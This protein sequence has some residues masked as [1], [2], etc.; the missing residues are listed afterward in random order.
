MKDEATGPIET[1]LYVDPSG[2]EGTKICSM[3]R[4]HD[5]HGS[6]AGIQK[7]PLKSPCPEQIDR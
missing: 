1:K 6:H 3:S 5:H 4:S 7:N 2:V